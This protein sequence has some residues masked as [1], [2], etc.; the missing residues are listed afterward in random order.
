MGVGWGAKPFTFLVAILHNPRVLATAGDGTTH[1]D[2]HGG[3]VLVTAVPVLSAWVPPLDGIGCE[4]AIASRLAP[5]P[6]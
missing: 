3:L 2:A 4:E 5:R 1:I 6:A